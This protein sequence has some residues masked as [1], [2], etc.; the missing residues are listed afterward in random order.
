MFAKWISKR[1]CEVYTL[2]HQ[3]GKGSA[4]LG[5]DLKG[6]GRMDL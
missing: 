6:T 5:S 4:R 2:N 1:M 3:A